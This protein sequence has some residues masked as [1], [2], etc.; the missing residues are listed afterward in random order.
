MRHFHNLVVLQKVTNMVNRKNII[1][2]SIKNF[3]G[4]VISYV[5]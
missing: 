3:G 4:G 5:I 1:V 2:K